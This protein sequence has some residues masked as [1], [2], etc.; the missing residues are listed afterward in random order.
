M[1]SR[2]DKPS[3]K[4]RKITLTVDGRQV[5]VAPG[6]TVLKAAG[7][8][9]VYVPKLCDYH[10][11]E[12]YGA[13]RMC[14]VEIEGQRGLPTSCTTEAAEGMVVTTDSEEINAVRRLI[15]EMLIADHPADCLSCSSNQNCELQKVAA[16]LGV[17]QQRLEKTGREPVR[18][19]SNPFFT[20]DSSKCILCGRCVR[21]CHELRGVG[22]IELAGRGFESRIASFADMPLRD[23]A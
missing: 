5:S 6:T 23:S 10:K 1:I 13:C 9:G 8:A 2:R 18:D 4:T 17:R 15:C 20:R 12:P 7:A 3:V 22:A 16:H 21:L 11:L 19:E 14:I